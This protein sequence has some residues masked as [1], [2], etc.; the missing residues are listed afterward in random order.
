VFGLKSGTTEVTGMHDDYRIQ[1]NDKNGSQP[2]Q[3]PIT[4]AVVARLERRLARIER[5]IDEGIGAYLAARFP[6]G[7]GKTDRWGRRR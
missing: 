2:S 7:D 3:S 5:L 1:G 6:Y 4:P